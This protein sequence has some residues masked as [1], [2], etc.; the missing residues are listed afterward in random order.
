MLLDH[1]RDWEKGPWFQNSI[2][3]VQ[4]NT[5]HAQF[6]ALGEYLVLPAEEG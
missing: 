3:Q 6:T 4:Q 1:F 2:E 5:H